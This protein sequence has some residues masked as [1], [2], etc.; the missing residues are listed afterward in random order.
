MNAAVWQLNAAWVAGFS[1]SLS[2][3]AAIGAQN[4]FV[5]RQGLRREHVAA[6]VGVCVLLDT[7]LMGAGIG[8]IA[9]TLGEHPLWL[10]GIGLA[11]AIALFVYGCMALKRALHPSVLHASAHGAT[12]STKRVIA[13]AL[14]ISLLNP[15]VYLDT[16]VLVGSVGAQQSAD[17]RVLFWLG[18][19]CASAVWFTSLGFGARVLT[20]LFKRPSAWRWLDLGV[21]AIM[22]SLAWSLWQ[23]HGA[24]WIQSALNLS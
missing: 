18:A 9:A 24:A 7:L 8:G 15:H 13:Q 14:S 19:A 22:F 21:A 2:L 16:V 5:L 1:L 10:Q 11:G 23:S 12:L 4:T 6:V 3:I 17:G 20:P